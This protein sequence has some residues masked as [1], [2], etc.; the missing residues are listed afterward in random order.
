MKI[1]F[2]DEKVFDIDGVYNSQN[3]R[4]WA[5][6]RSDADRRNG[7]HQKRKF[8]SKVMVWLSVC[9]KGASPLVIFNKG[10]VDHDRYIREVL[11]A[12]LEYGNQVFGS[13]WTF[14][15]DGVK[16]HAHRLT[17]E[18]CRKNCPSFIDKDQ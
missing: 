12:A 11:Q 18:W 4:L 15:Q 16:S 6:S 10:T 2:L 8:T 9:S 14:Q 7:V 13:D 17:R 5:V 3:N 1:M